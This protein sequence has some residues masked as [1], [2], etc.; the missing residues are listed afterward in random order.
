MIN[1]N[2]KA[3]LNET[4]IELIMNLMNY[5]N[6]NCQYIK[7]NWNK[8]LQ[9]ISLLE[10]YLLEPENNIILNLRNSQKEKFTEKEI[11]IFLNKRDNLSLNISDA[12]CESIFSKTELFENE[13]IIRFIN[14]LCQ[15]SKFELDSYY[16]P[17]LFSLKKLVEIAHFN[18]FRSAFYWKK[19]WKII[20]QYLGDIIINY[21]QENIWKQALDSLKQILIKLLEKEEYLNQIY[22][23]QENI[24]FCF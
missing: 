12:I 15:V 5:I 1:L 19:I 8:I 9:M 6:N 20:S 2:E 11:K 4:M 10:Y 16:I 18:I 22:M 24:F 17:R 3:E 13:V 21:S 14:D 23:F 7:C